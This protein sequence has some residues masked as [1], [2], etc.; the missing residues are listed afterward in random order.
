MAR[1]AQ[2][3]RRSPIWS[4]QTTALTTFPAAC[5]PSAKP[6]S[7]SSIYQ[8][9]DTGLDAKRQASVS[10]KTDVDKAALT[11]LSHSQPEALH[12]SSCWRHSEFCL[13]PLSFLSVPL[14]IACI[15]SAG[16]RCITF[17]S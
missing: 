13:S 4:D 7:H 17:L 6:F 3:I 11:N 1:A 2:I 8:A 15:L 9:S 10:C 12:L 16:T 5:A 14:C